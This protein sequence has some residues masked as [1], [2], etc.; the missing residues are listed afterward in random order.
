ML[1]NDFWQEILWG[2]TLHLVCQHITTVKM[3]GTGLG[4]KIAANPLN[5]NGGNMGTL[6]SLMSGRLGT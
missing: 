5:C 6:Q 2:L 1:Q 3:G 4:A